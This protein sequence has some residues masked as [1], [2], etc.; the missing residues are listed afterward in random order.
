MKVIFDATFGEPWVGVLTAFFRL[1]KVPRP[2]FQHLYD[3]VQRDAKDD[4]WVPLIV[5]QD[6]LIISADT[7]RGSKPRLPELCKL[8]QKTHI[9]LSPTMHSKAKQFQKARAIIVL[10]PD[11]MRALKAPPGSRFQIEATDSSYDHFKLVLKRN[12][13]APLPK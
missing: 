1:H 5:G 12:C 13:Q 8:Y 3:L 7:G 6:C 10:W 2:R 11:I 9:I 4:E